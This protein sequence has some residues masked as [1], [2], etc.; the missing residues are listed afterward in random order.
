M[1]RAMAPV[2]FIAAVLAAVRL[3]QAIDCQ[4]VD[5]IISSCLGYLQEGGAHP[6]MECCDSFRNLLRGTPTQQDRRDACEC[7]K[8]TAARPDI[9]ADVAAVLPWSCGLASSIT[10]SRDINCQNVL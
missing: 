3:G 7:L 6:P 1:N 8:A 5:L 4:T 9:K 2:I 10:I